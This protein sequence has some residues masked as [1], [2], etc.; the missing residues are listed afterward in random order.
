MR[1][2]L[3]ILLPLLAPTILYFILKQKVGASPSIAAKD[4]P[5]VWLGGIGMLLAAVLMTAWALFSGGPA[6][7][8]YERTRFEDGKVIPGRIIPPDASKP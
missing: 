1:N 2:A 3:T 5:W 7:S 8:S 6:G 4:A